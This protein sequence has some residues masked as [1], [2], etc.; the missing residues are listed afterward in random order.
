MYMYICTE[1]FIGKTLLILLNVD[2]GTYIRWELRNRL[3][4]LSF[5]LVKAFD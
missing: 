4:L 3:H 5:D 2:H 1:L